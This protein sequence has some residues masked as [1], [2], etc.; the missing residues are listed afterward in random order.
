MCQRVTLRWLLQ[1]TSL[2]KY[3]SN[4]TYSIFGSF[5]EELLWKYSSV[6]KYFYFTNPSTINQLLAELQKQLIKNIKDTTPA[7]FTFNRSIGS[8]QYFPNEI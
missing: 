7:N 2:K 3:I 1:I 5:P 6:V 4:K 8:T